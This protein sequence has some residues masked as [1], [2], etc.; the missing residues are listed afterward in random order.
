MFMKLVARYVHKNKEQELVVSVG[1]SILTTSGEFVI[2]VA[3]VRG[4]KLYPLERYTFTDRNEANN[5]FKEIRKR[6]K[7]DRVM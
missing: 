4:M 2:E 1:C 5:K 3:T 7:F 6:H